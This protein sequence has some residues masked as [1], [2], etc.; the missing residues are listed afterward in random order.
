MTYLAGQKLR[1]SGLNQGLST[2]S[3]YLGTT[4]ALGSATYTA[5][6]FAT[7][8]QGTGAGITVS[9]GNTTFTLAAGLWEVK[10]SANV[11]QSSHSGL[12]A[13]FFVL[14]PI[15]TPVGTAYAESNAPVAAGQVSGAIAADILSDGTTVVI[16]QIY[17]A[18][19]ASVL[20]NT[21]GVA[22]RLTFKQVP[23]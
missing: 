21:N 15:V 5:V 4:S 7:L 14:A 16:P 9:G 6:P 22:P 11:D 2:Y 23:N 20:T 12:T 19:A 13:C 17:C 1:A 8:V 18:G 3:R 10:F